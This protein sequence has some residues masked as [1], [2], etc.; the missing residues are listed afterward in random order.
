MKIWL[1]EVRPAPR[2]YI[3]CKSVNY[4]KE[5]VEMAEGLRDGT[6][7][8]FGEEPSKSMDI[9][10]LNLDHDLGDYTKDGGDGIKLLD[11]LVERRT[12]YPIV[13]HTMNPVGKANMERMINVFWNNNN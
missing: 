8:V 2:G 11:W 3:W 4:A 1:D 9:E 10:E 12:F 5:I 13:L 6:K 7:A